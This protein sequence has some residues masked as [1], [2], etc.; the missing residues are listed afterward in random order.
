[1]EPESSLPYSQALATPVPILSQH[2]PVPTTPSHFLKTKYNTTE[3]CVS[4][5][6]NI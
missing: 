5:D 2:H 1:M 6:R 4:Y 3:N